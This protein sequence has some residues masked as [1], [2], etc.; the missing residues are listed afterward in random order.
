MS[1]KIEGMMGVLREQGV[2]IADMMKDRD[3]PNKRCVALAQDN[4]VLVTAAWRIQH[5]AAP[6]RDEPELLPE[7]QEITLDPT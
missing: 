7:S 5:E 1:V 6:L 3:S 4:E 2:L